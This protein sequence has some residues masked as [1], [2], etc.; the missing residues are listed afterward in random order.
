MLRV[1]RLSRIIANLAQM[2][3]AAGV[4][5][6]LWIGLREIEES[7]AQNRAEV[8]LDAI[9]RVQ[10]SID[11]NA[12]IAR[13]LINLSKDYAAKIANAEPFQIKPE[14]HAAKSDESKCKLILPVQLG[15]DGSVDFENRT[16]FDFRWSNI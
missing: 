7:R 4:F 6:G 13:N 11:S 14:C 2:V 1:L 10:E 15:G 9:K 16:P 5:V 12:K 8:A 3:G